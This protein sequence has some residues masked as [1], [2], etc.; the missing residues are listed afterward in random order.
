MKKFL[1][2]LI[3]SFT[4]VIVNGQ[5]K[6]KSYKVLAACGQCQFS[7]NNSVGCDLAIQ[8]AGKHYWVNGSKMS[9]HGDEHAEDGMCKTIRRAKVVGKLENDTITV[10]EFTLLKK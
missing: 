6:E 9:D 5:T 8:I 2:I 3:L 7:M 1:F 4:S 10:S